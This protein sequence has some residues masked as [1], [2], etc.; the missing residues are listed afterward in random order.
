M[1]KVRH[2]TR[3]LFQYQVQSCLS[4]LL[5][6]PRGTVLHLI[7]AFVSVAGIEI[8]VEPFLAALE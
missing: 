2:D 3:F 4:C 6:D 5:G 8:T 1:G 7:S